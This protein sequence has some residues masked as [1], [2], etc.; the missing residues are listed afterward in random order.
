MIQDG[1][2]HR[3]MM[4]VRCLWKKGR[5]PRLQLLAGLGTDNPELV[6]TVRSSPELY[7][8]EWLKLWLA[9]KSSLYGFIQLGN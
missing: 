2:S 5:I 6:L 8:P 9:W 3:L 4:A 7:L 1:L